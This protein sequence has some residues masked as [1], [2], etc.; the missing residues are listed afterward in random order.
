MNPKQTNT[1]LGNHQ[2]VNLVNAP[3]K[4]GQKNYSQ[5]L[6]R[7]IASKGTNSPPSVE[8]TNVSEQFTRF[9]YRT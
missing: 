7:A 1:P 8:P 3:P 5:V 9:A 6:R 4:D 2:W